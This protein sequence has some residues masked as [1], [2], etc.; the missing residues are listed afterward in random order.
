MSTIWIGIDVGTQG[1][2]AAAY[3]DDGRLLAEGSAV[4]P[5]RSPAFGYMTHDPELDWWGGTREALSPVLSA[6]DPGRIGGI[7][8]AGLFP[9]VCLVDDAGQVTVEGI[10]YGDGRAQSLVRPISDQLGVALNGDEVVPRLVWLQRNAPQL[11]RR[12][13]LA[14]GP[15]GY[16]AFRL[17]GVASIDPHSA[18][19]WGGIVDGS[20]TGWDEAAIR[21]LGLP[22]GLL[23]PIRRPHEVVGTVTAEAARDTGLPVGVPVVVGATDT[24][25][26]LLGDGVIRAGE[27]MVY[28]GS[29]GTLLVCT[30]D[31][32]RAVN[33]PAT[34]APDRPYRLS[35]YALNL[36]SFLEH[37]RDRVFGGASY[38]S[39]D[40]EAA[41]VPPGAAGLFVIPYVSGKVL[42]QHQ[43]N[44]RGAIIGLDLR[45]GRA[46]LW[47]A[48][49]ESFGY[50]LL[51][52]RQRLEDEVA[53]VVAA[54]GGASSRVWR[55]IV[56][57]MT[58]WPQEIAAPGGSAR[59][60]AFLAAYG[61]GAVDSFRDMEGRWLSEWRARQ[62]T[63]RSIPDAAAVERYR[64]LFERWVA[65]EGAVTA[66]VEQ[67]ATDGRARSL[68]ALTNV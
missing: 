19:R 14:L 2:R 33:D 56:S 21:A 15:T 17:T 32:E 66:L 46:E 12:S 55:Q 9:A 65:C 29:S 23:P 26:Q 37:V 5:P 63:A 52:A 64:R 16:V 28:Y 39:L 30:A 18:V 48:M 13:R 47:R 31:L 1:V 8:I 27:A 45:H 62:A 24:L 60:A 59:G 35:A 43:A 57:D 49:L 38:A 10:L 22:L 6:V 42:P 7:G 4:R 11:V 53:S 58:G 36:G 34:F 50:L 40:A 20:R 25:A 61:R 67:V 44:A 68:Q 41:E 51:E 3:T 54:G